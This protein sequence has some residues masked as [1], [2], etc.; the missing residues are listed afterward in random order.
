MSS[1]LT[2]QESER[3][4]TLYRASVEKMKEVVREHKITEDELHIAGDY[5]NRLGAAGFS[6]S[7]V[8]MALALTSAEVT[9]PA[10]GTRG[11][12]EGP[13]HRHGHILRAD[14]RL[15]DRPL[16][17]GET[18]LLLS[19]RV[20]NA[21]TGGPIDGTAIDMWQTDGHGIYDREGDELRGIVPTD[22][23]GRYSIETVLPRFYSE[24]DNDPIGELLQAMGRPNCRAGHIHVKVL[25][26]G[27]ERLTTQLFIEGS[28]YLDS[29]YVEGAVSDDLILSVTQ[30]D[31]PRT[32]KASFD[33][34][35]LPGGQN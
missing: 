5:L 4:A 34:R 14:G 27:E 30:T 9:K 3:L 8:D 19:G 12:L 15:L 20:L 29:D 1:N 11:N 2:P 10:G 25:E 26:N 17:D 6:R 23:Q 21:Q 22:D 7:L 28:E 33:F 18:R 35:I 24:H 31:D 13:L 32:V 16:K